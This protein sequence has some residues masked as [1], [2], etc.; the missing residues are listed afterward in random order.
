MADQL[1]REIAAIATDAEQRAL[2][3]RLLSEYNEFFNPD[4]SR[5]EAELTE[6]R[7]RLRQRALERGWEPRS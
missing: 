1:V 7:D 6:L 2:A 3:D 5:L 4:V